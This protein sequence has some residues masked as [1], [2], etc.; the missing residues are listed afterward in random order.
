MCK[1]LLI[2]ILAM[3]K[4]TDFWEIY[5]RILCFTYN[6]C[7]CTLKFKISL[8]P[9]IVLEIYWGTLRTKRGHQN[10][11]RQQSLAP[12]MDLLP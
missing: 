7:L 6:M 10:K 4:K 1:K 3:K 5:E 2:R 8:D 11:Q 9:P 12:M